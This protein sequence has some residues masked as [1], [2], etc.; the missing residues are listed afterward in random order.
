MLALGAKPSWSSRRP[1][2]TGLWRSRFLTELHTRLRLSDATFSLPDL[3]MV[4]H[5]ARRDTRKSIS[6]DAVEVEAHQHKMLRAMQ[7]M[8]VDMISRNDPTRAKVADTVVASPARHGDV[9]YRPDVTL[10][11]RNRGAGA[12]QG[13][14]SVGSGLYRAPAA[15]AAGTGSRRRCQQPWPCHPHRRRA[16]RPDALTLNVRVTHT[17]DTSAF[18]G[19]LR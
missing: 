16:R 7:I 14:G 13:S 3:S 19:H 11:L 8:R 17:A 2:G 15:R 4:L 9:M 1:T 10:H 18:L 5:R 12:I 6:E